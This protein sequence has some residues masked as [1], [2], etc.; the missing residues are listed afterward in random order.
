M[1]DVRHNQRVK[2]LPTHLSQ[3]ELQERILIPASDSQLATEQL[4][5]K[6]RNNAEIA[7]NSSHKHAGSNV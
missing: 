5:K 6:R 3:Q 2:S 1:E 7:N 4:C